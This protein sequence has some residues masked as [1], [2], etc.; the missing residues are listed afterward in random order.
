MGPEGG[1]GPLS[2]AGGGHGGGARAAGAR[3][4]KKNLPRGQRVCLRGRPG[5]VGGALRHPQDAAP[6]P[7]Q[8]ATCVGPPATGH[9]APAAASA[10]VVGGEPPTT[11]AGAGGGGG[12]W[13]SHVPLMAGPSRPVGWGA[14]RARRAAAAA[15]IV[16]WCA[17]GEGRRSQ[18]PLPAPGG[19][20]RRAAPACTQPA[21]VPRHQSSGFLCAQADRGGGPHPAPPVGQPGLTGHAV[22]HKTDPPAPAPAPKRGRAP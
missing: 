10:A 8:A 13:P 16:A 19:T 5:P 18:A 12:W 17:R 15:G 4:V 20:R 14:S 3:S 21:G 1:A 22:A 6:R 2:C 11:S 7:V 9:G